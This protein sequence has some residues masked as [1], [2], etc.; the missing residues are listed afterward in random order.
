M[1]ADA[2]GSILCSKNLLLEYFY[3][4]GMDEIVKCYNVDVGQW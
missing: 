3:C 4:Y 1:G 2:E